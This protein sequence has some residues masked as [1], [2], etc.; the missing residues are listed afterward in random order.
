MSSA[1]PSAK[2][3]TS[4]GQLSPDRWGLGPRPPARARSGARRRRSRRLA[5]LRYE[6]VGVREHEI[7]RFERQHALVVAGPP[8]PH[9]GAARAE[10]SGR[11]RFP[12]GQAAGRGVRRWSSAACPPR[13]S[14][15]RRLRSCPPAG[16]QQHPVGLGSTSPGSA[17]S[18]LR[19]S[20][21]KRAMALRAAISPLPATSPTSR[22]ISS[23]P[24][25]AT[26]RRHRPRPARA[27]PARTTAGLSPELGQRF[28]ARTRA[29][30]HAM[31]RSRW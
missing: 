5:A 25:T 21:K 29:S 24:P 14:R 3:A 17:V 11:T 1:S 10:S 28:P 8:G 4:S 19:A 13:G 30:A 2:S 12:R 26:R 9:A 7:A 27:R 23:P 16:A 15:G 20:M 6:P 18:Q 31:R 22:A